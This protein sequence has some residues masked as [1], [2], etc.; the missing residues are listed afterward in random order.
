MRWGRR[1]EGWLCPRCRTVYPFEAGFI[2]AGYRGHPH[3]LV[4]CTNVYGREGR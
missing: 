3:T 2:C 4:V 1:L